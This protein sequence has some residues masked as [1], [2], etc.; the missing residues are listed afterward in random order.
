MITKAELREYAKLLDLNLGQAEKDYFQNIILFTIYRIYGNEI[1]FKGGTALKKCY[2]LKRFSE[3][4]D[5]TSSIQP[6][7]DKIEDGLK[8]FRISFETM[9]KEFENCLK[10]AVLIQGPLYVNTKNS[11]CRIE[12]DF[13]FRENVELNPVIKT[14][15]RF[16]EEIPSFDVY[17][18]QEKEILAEKI[19]AIMTRTKARDVYDAWFLFEKGVGF[20]IA[21]VNKK[22]SYFRETWN[23]EKFSKK[24]AEAE[25]IWLTELKPLVKNVPEFGEV[26]K[27]ILNNIIRK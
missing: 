20:D 13:S 6:E 25:D 22:L 7:T 2:G 23:K 8:R 27:T 17:A 1:V 16:M 4:L 21:L 19:R 5:F 10:V 3:D 15:G 9:K 24:L 12:L 26:R 14:I 11:M 18:M